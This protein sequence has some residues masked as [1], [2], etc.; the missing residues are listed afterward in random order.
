MNLFYIILLLINKLWIVIF[1]INLAHLL[2][3]IIENHMIFKPILYYFYFVMN[4]NKLYC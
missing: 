2:P 3:G 4:Q 1:K